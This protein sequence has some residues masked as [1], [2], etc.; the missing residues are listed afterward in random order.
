MIIKRKTSA[1]RADKIEAK[2]KGN[3][4]SIYLYGDIGGYFGIDHLE[5]VKELNA[6][7]ADVI[8]VRIDSVGGDIFAARAMQTAIMQ[9]KAKVVAHIDGV[10]ASAASFL[11]MSAD[12]IEIV[13]GGFLMI[14]KAMSFL[15]IYGFFNE[16]GLHEVADQTLS[17]L[18]LHE[19]LNQAIASDY[20]KRTGEGTDTY[21]QMMEDETWLT[22]QEALDCGLV[23]RIYDG[24]PVN[25]KYDLDRFNK[26]PDEIKHRAKAANANGRETKVPTERD[27]E[28]ALRDVGYSR[29]QAKEILAKGLRDER[30]AQNE[31]DTQNAR[32]AQIEDSL[33]QREADNAVIPEKPVEAPP[34]KKK[35]RTA[36]ILTR[37]EMISPTKQ[38]D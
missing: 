8:H 25:G 20:S 27:A 6:L 7:D 5:W 35:D 30:D 24:E 4:S 15:D 33:P 19:K 37:A 2:A 3:E 1:I 21:L 22:A 14:H 26:V 17:E 10:A 36:D 31:T 38:E 23:D 32:E 34:K 9:H 29:N 11:A 16:S 12:E 18:K 28:K 13:D